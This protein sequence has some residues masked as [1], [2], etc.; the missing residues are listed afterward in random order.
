M[1]KSDFLLSL[2]RSG[3]H[4]PPVLSLLSVGNSYPASQKP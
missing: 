1:H 3:I 4:A 2:S